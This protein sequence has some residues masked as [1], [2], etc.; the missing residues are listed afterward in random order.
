MMSILNIL[1]SNPTLSAWVLMNPLISMFLF[2][3]CTTDSILMRSI[4]ITILSG[5]SYSIYLFYNRLNNILNC[6]MI[7]V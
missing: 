6:K 2:G 5:T 7:K 4:Y 1:S 3:F